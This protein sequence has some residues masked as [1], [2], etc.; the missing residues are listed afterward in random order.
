MKARRRL[1]SDDVSLW[2]DECHSDVIVS[3]RCNHDAKS[4]LVYKTISATRFGVL[5]RLLG[6]LWRTFDALVLRRRRASADKLSCLIWSSN[7]RIW[8]I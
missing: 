8:G 7:W 5:Q 1:Y 2:R 6:G 4:A 3:L